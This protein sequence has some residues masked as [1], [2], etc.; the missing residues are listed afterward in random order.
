VQVVTG[1]SEALV[2]L[3]WL[4]AERGANLI[5]PRP[6]FATFSALPQ[7]LGSEIRFYNLRRENRFCIDLSEIQKLA[8]ANTKLILVNS[9]HNPTGTTITDQEFDAL[10]DFTAQR[11]IQLVSD[12]VSPRV[13]PCTT[14]A[15]VR[16]LPGC[17]R[18]L[19]SAISLKLSRWL[20]Y[21]WAG[22]S[23]P[24]RGEDSSTGTREP[25]SQ[26]QMLL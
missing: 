18:L 12:E 25:I 24:I 3:M 19:S 4:A 26:S 15:K 11:G 5:L 10:H 6:C 20:G 14:M 22:S 23:N 16:A 21:V 13:T 17:P 1:A 8:D 7:S 2:I 9:P